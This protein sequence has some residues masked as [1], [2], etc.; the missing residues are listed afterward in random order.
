MVAR[1]WRYMS[2]GPST[3]P[4]QAVDLHQRGGGSRV[5]EVAGD[6]A[7]GRVAH[8]DVGDV[9]AAAHDVVEPAARLAH[10]PGGDLHD[11]VDLGGDVAL[12]AD[13]ALP[14]DGGRAGLQHGVADAQ[15]TRVVGGLFELAA[16]GDVEAGCR[17]HAR[18]S[19]TS[20]GWPA[21]AR[22]GRGR[23][24]LVPAGPAP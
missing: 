20:R 13:V 15:R 18:E 14:V 24:R 9:H 23:T 22:S 8:G 21:P 17:C 4:G 6:R 10:A 7:G 5:A 3:P 19:T 11:G 1:V 16:G 12:A 2:P